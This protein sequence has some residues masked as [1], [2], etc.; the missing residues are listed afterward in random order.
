MSKKSIKITIKEGRSA[1]NATE[2]TL[3]QEKFIPDFVRN[4]FSKESS[5]KNRDPL[6]SESLPFDDPTTIKDS[7]ERLMVHHFGD[8]DHDLVIDSLASELRKSF[9][10]RRFLNLYTQEYTNRGIPTRGLDF[11]WNPVPNGASPKEVSVTDEEGK[12][13]PIMSVEQATEFAEDAK[14]HLNDT[15]ASVFSDLLQSGEFNQA[16]DNFIF[17]V[18]SKA[19]SRFLKIA[20]QNFPEKDSSLLASWGTGFDGSSSSSKG[21]DSKG[22][23]LDGVDGDG[24]EGGDGEGDK[25][26]KET[27]P[28]P[29]DIEGETTPD[30]KLDGTS[31]KF[32]VPVFKKFSGEEQAQGA[33]ARS[34]ASQ[35]MKLFPNIPKEV[36]MNVLK[37]VAK[38]LK[39][40]NI[41]IQE[42]K[43][44][45]VQTLIE[46]L[47]LEKPSRAQRQK[48]K[49]KMATSKKLG[50]PTVKKMGSGK[51]LAQRP[52]GEKKEF[53]QLGYGNNLA[54]AKKAA[55]DWANGVQTVDQAGAEIEVDDKDVI[56]TI[57]K[58]KA[59]GQTLKDTAYVML[60]KH[61]IK[62]QKHLDMDT[63]AGLDAAMKVDQA[64]LG[65][66]KFYRAL[67]SLEKF[68]EDPKTADALDDNSAERI[69][70]MMPLKKKLDPMNEVLSQ[71]E[72]EDVKAD[73]NAEPGLASYK[74]RLLRLT[75][76]LI[77]AIQRGMLRYP[78]HKNNAQVAIDRAKKILSDTR[79]G[80]AGVKDPKDPGYSP[81]DT[82]IQKGSI[83]VRQLV[84]PQL[85][86][87]DLFDPAKDKQDM[88][89]A[90]SQ[91]ARL[92]AQGKDKEARTVLAKAKKKA[93]GAVLQ[94]DITKVIRR[95]LNKQMQRIG[96]DMSIVAENKELFE[97]ALIEELKNRGLIK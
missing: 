7:L 92:K 60:Y 37:G 66:F 4:I 30:D 12:K 49:Q 36:L 51:F 62:V 8:G 76:N 86:A 64:Y 68:L 2:K 39:G 71:K 79:K 47:L 38:Q 75:K 27:G 73:Q 23:G 28:T 9:G 43:D 26:D 95:F 88:R 25:G 93:G 24:T 81:A 11:D 74:V 55:Q 22:S 80:K 18:A 1:E 83:N 5:V 89:V 41:K 34:L 84:G 15:L 57:E 35:L 69:I 40:N 20:K 19:P 96:A 78:P 67:Q 10:A 58:P 42:N 65:I 3:I 17:E 53:H 70:K 52:D 31:S 77:S 16:D 97:T 6:N 85:K 91:A 14:R 48:N 56:G 13:K 21:D 32:A 45:F 72:K 54:A 82:E 63:P 50:Q 29:Q 44:L 87:A 59:P 46:Q 90:K 94:R 33:P 61:I